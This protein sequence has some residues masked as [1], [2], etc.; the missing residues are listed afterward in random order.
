[1]VWHNVII[2][3]SHSEIPQCNISQCR[4]WWWWGVL[5]SLKHFN[6]MKTW[7]PSFWRC[8]L[9]VKQ[10]IVNCP[11]WIEWTELGWRQGAR[12]R[13]TARKNEID[14]SNWTPDQGKATTVQEGSTLRTRSDIWIHLAPAP[15]LLP[16]LSMAVSSNMSSSERTEEG[17]EST[18]HPTN[19]QKK[20][21]DWNPRFIHSQ[22]R[23]F[24]DLCQILSHALS[25][26]FHFGLN[27]CGFLYTFQHQETGR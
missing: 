3:W 8:I 27:G 15:G 7:C 11:T 19:K 23:F 21:E 20:E 16:R 9:Y 2:K 18:P 12:K 6:S 10:H 22:R 5:S 1:M 13:R 26:V 17:Q 24:S 25:P 4:V 14:R